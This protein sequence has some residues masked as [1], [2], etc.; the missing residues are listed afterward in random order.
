MASGSDQT[1]ALLDAARVLERAGVAHALVGGIAVGIHCATPRATMDVDFAVSSGSDRAL[2]IQALQAGGFQLTSEHAHSINLRHR[3]GE[4]VQ[5]AI[6]PAFDPLIERAETTAIAGQQVRIVTRADLIEMKQRA[7]A[8]PARRRSK[9]LR[10]QAD[11]ELLKGDV[12]D[13][14]EGW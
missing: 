3:S 1:E 7:A 5:L 11:I 8:D 2:V 13:P 9:A 6:D 4:P 12:P 14:D 10:D